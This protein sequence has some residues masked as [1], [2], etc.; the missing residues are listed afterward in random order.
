MTTA[1]QQSSTALHVNG[2]RLLDSIHSTCEFGK[3]HPYG[4]HHT[5]TGMA[6]LSLNDDDKRV[7]LWFID[8]VK[9][10][11]CTV[12]IDQ[13]G[14]IFAVRPGKCQSAAPVMMGSHLDTQPTGG[15]Y[16]GILGVMAGLEVLR[17][18]HDNAYETK[19]PVGIINWTNEEGARFP[20]VTM[21]SGVWAGSTPLETAWSCLE[22]TPALLNSPPQ[23]VKQEL[24]RIGFLGDVPA[25]HEAQPLAAHFE[26]HIEQGPIL[27]D[28]RRKIG[29]VTG[30]QAYSW[31]EVEVKGRDS[32]AG[33]T[34]LRARRD[35]LLAAARM[36]VAS[37]A[38]AREADGLVTTGI[39]RGQ[40]G[41]VNTMAHT[42]NF[43]VDIRHP[44]DDKLAQMVA[45]CREA[46]DKIANDESE[47]GVSVKWTTL[48]ENNAVTFHK[49]CIEAIEQAAEETCAQLPSATPD[50]KLWKHMLSGAGHDSCHTS[51]RC[52][53]AMIFT[54]TRNGMSHTPD[55]YCSPEDCVTGAQ[56]LLGAVLRY[57]AARADLS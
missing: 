21:S 19:G 48:T 40:P 7:R 38:V 37:N 22:V 52:P 46:F 42:V 53:T 16:D 36:V 6:R 47:R 33:T 30:A 39:F 56:V 43:T 27:E 34:P 17:T 4:P 41:S 35:A 54:P 44:S 32:H 45:D 12:T 5:E 24:E 18:L 10:L 57:D 51:K 28:E 29:V 15:R 13:M 2:S 8:Q 11:G 9:A 31:F 1:A 49:D 55:E 3:A 23:T 20:M 14:N 26:L 50:H 25:S